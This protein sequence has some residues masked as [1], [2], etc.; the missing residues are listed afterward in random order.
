ME[1]E[2][3]KQGQ[4]LVS[5]IIPNYNYARFVSKA[6]TSVENQTYKNIQIIV[7]DN[8]ST[9]NSLEVLRELGPRITL[10]SQE[11]QGQSG[12]RN[13]GLAAAKGDFIA[14]LDADDTWLPTKIEKQLARFSDKDVGLV[15]TG[16]TR[17]DSQGKVQSEQLPIHRGWILKDFAL[18]PG[19]A[20]VGGESTA[21]VRREA[22]L[23]AGIFDRE[24]SIGSGWDMWRRIA[25]EWKVEFVNEPLALYLQHGSNLSM[26]LDVYERDTL[27][28]LDNMFSDPRSKEVFGLRAQS[29]EAHLLSLAGAY[30]KQGYRARSLKIVLKSAAH[31]PASFFKAAYRLIKRSKAQLEMR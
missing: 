29:Y 22:I 28:K 8:G 7:V 21:L 19:A 9:D 24:L 31:H 4:R 27:R 30:F 12:A 2:A 26:N 13:S 6:V 17:V 16:L 14:F 23:S 15:Y 5:V 11:N 18:S 20:V 1:M 10:I 25:S 3:D